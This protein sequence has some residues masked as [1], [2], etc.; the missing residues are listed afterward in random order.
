VGTASPGKVKGA[1]HD[2]ANPFF[3]IGSAG[4]TAVRTFHQPYYSSIKEHLA[5]IKRYIYKSATL[6]YELMLG[7][8][9]E[10]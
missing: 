8:P 10:L 6:S 2:S 3:I 4:H 7:L 9:F 1:N 5:Q